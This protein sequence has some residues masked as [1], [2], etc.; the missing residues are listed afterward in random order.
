MD[1]V[2]LRKVVGVSE[3]GCSYDTE[4]AEFDK[5]AGLTIVA[6]NGQEFLVSTTEDGGISICIGCWNQVTNEFVHVD[7]MVIRTCGNDSIVLT[8]IIK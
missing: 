3:T 1:K 2:S 7:N 4:K 8:P 5:V 6:E